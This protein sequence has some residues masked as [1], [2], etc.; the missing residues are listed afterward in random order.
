MPL[1][2]GQGIDTFY[3]EWVALCL[4]HLATITL[5]RTE[6]WAPQAKSKYL[7]FL[8]YHL[9]FVLAYIYLGLPKQ[10]V[11]QNVK[12]IKLTKIFK[13]FRLYVTQVFA[14]QKIIK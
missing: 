2:Y 13:Y 5:R 8:A 3:V 7:A 9:G 4:Q 10:P 14:Q 1:N 6:T 11:L 12:K